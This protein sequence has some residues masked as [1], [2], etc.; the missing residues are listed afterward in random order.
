MD[1]NHFRK[2]LKKFTESQGE[3]A[4]SFRDGIETAFRETLTNGDDAH[5]TELEYRKDGNGN[6]AW[7]VDLYSCDQEK[8]VAMQQNCYRENGGQAC[9]METGPCSCGAWH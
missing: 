4:K 5:W 2:N 9:D 1:K 8:F 7:Y 3:L 6:M